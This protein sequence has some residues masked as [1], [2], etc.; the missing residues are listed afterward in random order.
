MTRLE[1]GALK[2]IALSAGPRAF[3]GVT[4][5]L[6][7]VLISSPLPALDM[8]RYGMTREARQSNACRNFSSN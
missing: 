1:P 3:Q 4:A 5:R 2:R 6:A 7:A 8:A